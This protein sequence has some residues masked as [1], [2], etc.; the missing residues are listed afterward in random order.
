MVEDVMSNTSCC[1][2]KAAHFARLAKLAKH[3]DERCAYSELARLW[4]DMVRLAERFDREH[5]GDAKARI[6]SMMGKVEAVRQ[7]VA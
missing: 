2:K 1:L 5:D 3:A 7:T 6:Y 4:S